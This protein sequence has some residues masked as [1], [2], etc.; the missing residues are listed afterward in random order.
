MNVQP[1]KD[2]VLVAEN[3]RENKTETGIILEGTRG[4]AETARATVLAIGPDVTDVQ[5]GDLLLIDWTKAS[6]VKVGDVQR[7]IIK[8]EHILA[9]FD[10]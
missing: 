6:A 4:T 7:A 8:Q 10:K 3:K 1:L 5:V 9:V 2:N